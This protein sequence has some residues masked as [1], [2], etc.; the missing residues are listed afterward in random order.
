[1]SEDEWQS[2]RAPGVQ[3][4]ISNYIFMDEQW[5]L[6]NV[7]LWAVPSA[8]ANVILTS[9][10]TL[11]SSLS[12]NS[13]IYLPPGY[14]RALSLDLAISL[15]P[16]FG[17]ASSPVVAQLSSQL[18]QIKKKIRWLNLRGSRMSY[19]SAAQGTGGGGG[20]YNILDDQIE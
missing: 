14:S 18:S 6:A 15:A 13:I 19:S 7:Y 20:V 4:S 11:N 2:I 12:A 17:L 8:D 3:A 1:L 9:G 10:Q 5:P 16:N